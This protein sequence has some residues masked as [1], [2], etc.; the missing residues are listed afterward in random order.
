MR[1]A[2]FAGE[3]VGWIIEQLGP[4]MLCFA[5]DYPHPEGSRDPIGKFEA[6]MEGVDQAGLDAFYAGNIDAF[7]GNRGSG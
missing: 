1:F 5:S 4:D 6:T 3:P 2:P 7:L